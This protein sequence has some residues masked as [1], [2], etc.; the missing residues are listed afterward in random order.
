MRTTFQLSWRLLRGGGRRGLLGSLLTLAAVA[1]STGLLL[2]AVGA[3]HAFAAR[4]AADAWRHPAKAHGTPT[5]VEALTTDFVRGRPVT[6]VELAALTGD[7]PVPPGMKRFPKPGEVW[8]SP[9]LAS[10]MREVPADQLAARFPSRT[11]AG[12]LGRAAV[13]HPGELVAVV[14]RAPSD[15]SMTAARADTMAVDNVASPTR[16]DRYATGAQSSSALVYQIL[17][18]VASVLMAVPLLVFGGAAARLTVA[19]R[20]GRLAALRLVGATPGQ[21][22]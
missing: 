16:I 9:A 12:T 1:V 22:V 4:S 5:A 20:D 2:F 21:V 18:A 3:N 7:A 15:P 8:T 13:A 19:R 14:G 6:V 17:A 11:P 10:L